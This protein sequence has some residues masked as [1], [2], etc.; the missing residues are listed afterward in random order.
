MSGNFILSNP[1]RLTTYEADVFLG[2]GGFGH[3]WSGRTAYGLRVA[4][5]L[6]KPTSNFQ[7]DWECW[8]TEQGIYLQCLSHQ[9]I[10]STFDQFYSSEGYLVIV[11]EHARCNMKSLI[12][13]GARFSAK[14]IAAIGC[15]ILSAVHYLHSI[16]VIHRDISLVNVLWFDGAVAKLADFGISKRVVSVQDLARTFIGHKCYLPPELVSLGYSSKKSD[17]YQV[18]LVLL[19]LMLGRE[20]IPDFSTPEQAR[21]MILDGIPRQLAEG[22]IPTWGRVA[23]IV[24]VMLRRRDQYR[25]QE[26]RDVWGDL[27][28]EFKFQEMLASITSRNQFAPAIGTFK[29]R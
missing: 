14:D 3:V 20:P 7:R 8:N 21:Q 19:A 26:A 22:L 29:A 28:Q 2:E 4:L 13:S 6:I 9:H 23:E 17:I 27:I 11:M 10:V 1:T 25:Y 18:G 16:G 24:S 12:A 5:K 15:Q